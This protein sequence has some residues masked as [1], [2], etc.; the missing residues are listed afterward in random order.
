MDRAKE[1]LAPEVQAIIKDRTSLKIT[2]G[3]YRIA[4][5]AVVVGLM[6]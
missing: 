3:F 5:C 2:S 6:L 4:V 1:K